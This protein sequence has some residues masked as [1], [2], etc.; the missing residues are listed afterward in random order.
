MRNLKHIAVI[1]ALLIATLFAQDST[2][3][4][5]LRKQDPEYPQIAKQ[6]N[7]HGAVKIKLWITPQGSVRRSEYIGGHPLLAEAAINA[8]K[9]WK[10]EPVAHETTTVVEVRF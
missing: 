8:L 5:V 9:D 10:Y 3:R 6:M 4:K 1:T 7:L 2:E